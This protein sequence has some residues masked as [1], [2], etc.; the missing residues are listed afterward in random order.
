MID[1]KPLEENQSPQSVVEQTPACE[2][3]PFMDEE[4]KPRKASFL[5]SRIALGLALSLILGLVTA[6][7]CTLYMLTP[8]IG[9]A[10]FAVFFVCFI[11]L[12]LA[13]FR[14]ERYQLTESNVLCHRGSL[15]SDQ[16][17]DVDICNITYVEMSLPWL[18]YKLFKIGTIKI[19]SAGNAQ[20]ITFQT[21]RK[22]EEIYEQIQQ[23]LQSNGYQLQQKELLHEEKPALI[24]AVLQIVKMVFAS[25]LLLLFFSSTLI[26]F[27]DELKSNGLEVFPIIGGAIC[28]LLAVGVITVKLLDILKR[29]YRVYDDVVTYEEG[30]LTRVKAFIPYENI[31]DASTKRTFL[32]QLLNLYEVVI[33][34]QGSAKEIKFQF[35]KGGVYLSG[36]IQKLITEASLKPSPS[37]QLQ[38]SESSP[39][40]STRKEPELLHPKDAW[41]ADLKMHGSRVFLP[42]LLLFPILP[43]FIISMIHVSIRFFA[44]SYRVRPSFIGHSFSFL[45]TVNRE[46]AHDKITGLVI[47]ENIFDRIFGTFTLRFWSIGSKESLELAHVRRSEVDLD[48]LLKLV[49]IPTENGNTRI[50]PTK[51]SPFSW[52]RAQCYNLLVFLFLIIGSAGLAIHSGENLLFIFTGMALLIPFILLIYPWLFYSKQ[53]VKLHD[54][55]IEATQGV[56]ARRTYYARYR[57]IK[58][59]L[60]TIYPGGKDGSLKVFVAGEQTLGPQGKQ[61]EKKGQAQATI[62]CS[63]NLGFLPEALRSSELLDDILAGRMEVKDSSASL[64]PLALITESKRGV[65]N[66]LVSLVFLSIIIFPL[67]PFIV[68]TLPLTLLSTKRWRYR[69]EAGRIVSSWGLLFRKRES[70][71]LDRVDSQQQKQGF[72]GKL[73]KNGTV[74]IMTA[75]SS[76]PDLIIKDAASYQ[77]ISQ[78]IKKITQKS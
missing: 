27:Y 64:E 52:M 37:D 66:A 29:T 62:P 54:H 63:F 35:L 47:K 61:S 41:I 19:H 39:S 26:A 56:I 78:E 15:V 7:V 6:L 25:F 44:T 77:A 28:I 72:L 70:I 31:A 34:C 45:N 51:F 57:N 32:D 22:P 59:T 69:L 76:Q 30:F 73:F 68:I 58:K 74:K 50:I 46:F 36:C 48:A 3:K 14:K 18:R 33:S 60:T 43:I 12:A 40:F 71:L 38:A 20:P 23:R 5:F 9:L 21:I 55:H 67:L 24:G 8:W 49:G 53:E 13:A 65:G 10:V 2:L 1:N 16:T 11:Y 17:T 4:F 75:G 42:V